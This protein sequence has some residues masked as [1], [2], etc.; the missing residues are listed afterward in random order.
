MFRHKDTSQIAQSQFRAARSLV[1]LQLLDSNSPGAKGHS[2]LNKIS[3]S[4]LGNRHSAASKDG[5]NSE[6]QSLI[7]DNPTLS[8]YYF[9][10][11]FLNHTPSTTM[12]LVGKTI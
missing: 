1:R 10:F 7:V 5:I 2:N 6:K 11:F 12:W 3:R 4:L 9:F 8:W